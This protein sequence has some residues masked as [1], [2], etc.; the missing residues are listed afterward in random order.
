MTAQDLHIVRRVPAPWRRVGGGVIV[1]P[2]GREDFDLLS[3][4]AAATWLLLDTDMSVTELRRA[5]A[6]SLDL[7]GGPAPAEVEGV[8]ADLASRG[9]VEDV[10]S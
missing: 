6:S 2:P 3:G 10:A 1:A 5:L 9:L 4:P 7:S 8:L